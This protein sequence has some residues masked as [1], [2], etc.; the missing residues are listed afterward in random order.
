MKARHDEVDDETDADGVDERPDA[1]ALAQA[2][3]AYEDDK[4]DD[5]RPRADPQ[6]ERAR[7]A[8][9]ED[10]PWVESESGNHEHARGRAVKE[11]AREQLRPAAN[12][13]IGRDRLE[14]SAHVPLEWQAM[15]S[16]LDL[17]RAVV[18]FPVAATDALASLP[19]LAKSLDRLSDPAGPIAQAV[20]LRDSLETLASGGGSLDRLADV[21]TT[22]ER[23]ATLD[24]SLQKLGELGPT[25]ERISELGEA[26]KGIA[27]LEDSVKQIA[28]LE[29]SLVKLTE[30]A[31]TMGELQVS[32]ATLAQAVAPLQGATERIG[33]MV[34][35]IPSRRNRVAGGVPPRKLPPG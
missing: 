8:L 14:Q 3:P 20:T 32:I 30:L 2:N 28:A 7:E 9:M 27:A 23:L 13:A 1:E 4:A 25:L 24:Q 11:H 21:S 16:L 15:P 12:A 18:T 34:D 19:R 10:I 35:R 33:R 22:L 17:P 5:D 29:G 31:D 26:V 6:T